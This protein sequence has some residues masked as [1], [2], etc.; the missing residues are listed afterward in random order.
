GI[1]VLDEAGSRGDRARN[2]DTDAAGG[3]G[4]SLEPADHVADGPDRGGVV[5]PGSRHAVLGAR[6][7]ASIQRHA[8]D[9]GAAEINADPQGGGWGSLLRRHRGAPPSRAM[10]RVMLSGATLRP[11]VKVSNSDSSALR[12]SSTASSS[13]GAPARARTSPASSPV[14]WRN[15]A[16]RDGSSAR[17]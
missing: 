9:L 2:P 1:G 7:A 3:T 14:S 10:A 5:V 15:R 17:K 6:A 4:R 12:C 13:S 11:A 16:R 8:R